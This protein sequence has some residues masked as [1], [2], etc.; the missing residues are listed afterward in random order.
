[1]KESAERSIVELSNTCDSDT[2]VKVR[3]RWE[4]DSSLS[5]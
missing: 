3:R 2:N 1:M 5:D 4:A